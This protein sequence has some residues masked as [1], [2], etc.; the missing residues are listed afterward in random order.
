MIVEIEKLTFPYLL[1]PSSMISEPFTAH[2][3]FFRQ[4][5]QK[6]MMIFTKI[7]NLTFFIPII[8][9]MLLPGH[10]TKIKY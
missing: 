3:K 6:K 1:A 10:N 8:I 2:G 9:P 4:I 5:Y 7:E